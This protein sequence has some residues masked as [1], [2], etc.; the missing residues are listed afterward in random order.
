MMLD[1]FLEYLELEKRYS[2]HTITS[3]RKDLEDKY[4]ILIQGNQWVEEYRL[5]K[6]GNTGRLQTVEQYEDMI[7]Y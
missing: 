3:Y 7:K 2:P 5:F 4:K 6:S 1:K